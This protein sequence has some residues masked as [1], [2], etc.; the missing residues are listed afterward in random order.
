MERQTLT[1]LSE[2]PSAFLFF[3]LSFSLFY[4]S[5]RYDLEVLQNTDKSGGSHDRDN[6][7]RSAASIRLFAFDTQDEPT[8]A[9]L[10]HA[11]LHTNSEGPGQQ[12][13]SGDRRNLDKTTN[14][15]TIKKKKKKKA[16]WQQIPRN[17]TITSSS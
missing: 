3:F 9:P 13:G 7:R 15:K 1:S 14:G 8:E 5:K 6:Q 17:M 4:T 12:P 10:T 11:F 16:D 2:T